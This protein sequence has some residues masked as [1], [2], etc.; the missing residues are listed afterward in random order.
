MSSDRPL[1]DNYPISTNRTN[2]SNWSKIYKRGKN[3]HFDYMLRALS[4]SEYEL[5]IEHN[6]VI[7][8]RSSLEK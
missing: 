7:E 6:S 8:Y 3:F 5:V 2:A 1:M 4:R